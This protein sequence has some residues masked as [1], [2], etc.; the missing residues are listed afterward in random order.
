M[1]RKTFGSRITPGKEGPILDLTG[2]II[3]GSGQVT[4]EEWKLALR[5]LPKLPGEALDKLTTSVYVDAQGEQKYNAPS[6]LG[7]L[8]RVV[9]D[10]DLPAL[11]AL[12]A[13]RH[14]VLDLNDYAGMMEW[15]VSET[16]EERPTP[17]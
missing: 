15:I 14:R 12:I 13:D 17:P 2:D 8:R 5:C 4:G 7:F 6:V 11:E 16:T 3:D 10:D 1:A 9:V